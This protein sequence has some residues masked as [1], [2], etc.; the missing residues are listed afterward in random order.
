MKMKA[1]AKEEVNAKADEEVR[2]LSAENE[3]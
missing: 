3:T 1:T 2:G